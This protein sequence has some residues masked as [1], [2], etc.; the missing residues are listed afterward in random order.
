MRDV[1]WTG[2]DEITFGELHKFSKIIFKPF[3][4]WRG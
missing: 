4:K 2:S 1:T 3:K